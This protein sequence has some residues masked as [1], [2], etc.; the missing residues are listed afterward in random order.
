M[1][2]WVWDYVRA[3]SGD[4]GYAEVRGWKYEVVGPRYNA[5]P[6]M[7][8]VCSPCPTKRDVFLRRVL[9][10]Q[11]GLRAPSLGEGCSRSLPLP[12]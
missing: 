3:T 5:R 7:T 10:G 12:L 8:D 4:G 2:R 6:F 1:P 9:G 11:R